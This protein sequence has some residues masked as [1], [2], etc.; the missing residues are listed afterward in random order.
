[1]SFPHN[2][3]MFCFIQ[4]PAS[5]PGTLI[6]SIRNFLPESILMYNKKAPGGA[7]FIGFRILNNFKI[8]VRMS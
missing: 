2:Y 8:D 5:N 7:F 3:K 4:G 6:G 1:M